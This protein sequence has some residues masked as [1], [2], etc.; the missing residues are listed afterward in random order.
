MSR[1]TDL[2]A[3][4]R[5]TDRNHYSFELSNPFFGS[6]I[7]QFA[8][9]GWDDD[10]YSIERDMRSF[11]VF[12]KFATNELSFPKDGRDFL[13]N[14]Y[15]GFGPNAECTIT[16][17]EF[18]PWR[19][20]LTK[21][22]GKLDFSTY[23][24]SE[25][26]VK[27][28]VTDGSFTDLVLTRAKTKVDILKDRSIDDQIITPAALVDIGIPAIDVSCNAWFHWRLPLESV[29]I[30]TDHVIPVINDYSSFLIGEMRTPDGTIGNI[31]GS[32]FK[33][34]IARTDVLLT[35]DLYITSQ[36]TRPYKLLVNIYDIDNN[37][38]GAVFEEEIGTAFGDNHILRD[39]TFNMNAGDW[40]QVMADMGENMITYTAATIYVYDAI[41]SVEAR[42]IKGVKYEEALRALVAHY[43][44]QNNA[45]SS[46]VL[47]GTDLGY[48]GAVIPGRYLR[49]NAS[50]NSGVSI[51]LNDLFDSLRIMNL[52]LGVENNT[53]VIEPM[54]HFFKT[55]EVLDLSDRIDFST[56]GK[57]LDQNLMANRVQMGFTSYNYDY[58]GGIFECNTSSEWTN[59]MKT[60]DK[61]FDVISQYRADSA[62]IFQAFT[63]TDDTKDLK[64]DE[65]IYLM[66]LRYAGYPDIVPVL[67]ESFIQVEGSIPSVTLFNL[68][69]SPART[70]LRWGRYV[71][72][73]L[74]KN[75]TSNLKWQTSD[76]NT[77][78]ATQAPGE[79]ALL[80]ENADI[81][82]ADL[83]VNIWI[84]EIY[85][86]EVPIDTNDFA[87]ITAEPYGLFK[88]AADTW[89]FL[90]SYKAKN[91]NNKSTFKLLRYNND[92]SPVTVKRNRGK[93]YNW[94]AASDPN[95]APVGFHVP[96]NLEQQT[97]SF[98][99]EDNPFRVLPHGYRGL[100]GTFTALDSSNLL[101]GSDEFDT[102]GQSME[103]S[104]DGGVSLSALDKTHGLTIRCIAD[105]TTLAEGE[106]STVTD[107]D[108]N[109]YPTKCINGVE[110]MMQ[111]LRTEHYRS[112]AAIAEVTG[113]SAW[114]ALTTAAC[115]SYDNDKGYD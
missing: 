10:E 54:E 95:I 83:A 100:D 37:F 66:S 4:N 88:I 16:A 105:N 59:V 28:K 90:L 44:G 27:I 19:V 112:G 61:K 36:Y 58:S 29:F 78:L 40:V 14:I 68:I 92:Y 12:R 87:A 82:V 39:V 110:W 104:I 102:Y 77:T 115:C 86:F 5:S 103:A 109:I 114:A 96:T 30:S 107:V 47:S 79:S 56:I 21:F 50:I 18:T 15:E 53:L 24:I 7:L 91:E 23:K 1:Q 67:N 98:T 32:I 84:P 22:I 80:Y 63:E 38:V 70:L 64:T 42:T 55:L 93:L 89:G 71:R 34:E 57:Q 41:N 48:M 101:W 108:G 69:Y 17:T 60:I 11:G 13:R 49:Q 46:S 3:L 45:V 106:E 76:K 74:W 73:M 62:G 31:S 72:A 6:V 97:L 20:Q 35:I 111:N 8:P 99:V 75:T 2:E 85:E 9:D 65:T 43:T 33:T 52:G 113:N 51:S 26:F 81:K 25:L 94:Y